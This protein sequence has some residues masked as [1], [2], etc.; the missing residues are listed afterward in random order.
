MV[1]G[2]VCERDGL[3][4]KEGISVDNWK[5]Y[6]SRERGTPISLLC[7][8]LCQ[9]SRGVGFRFGVL[10]ASRNAGSF[11]VMPRSSS[12]ISNIENE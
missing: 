1:N 4:Y 11:T 10:D 9:T 7:Q 6:D 8:T 3:P 5:W 2:A 12:L